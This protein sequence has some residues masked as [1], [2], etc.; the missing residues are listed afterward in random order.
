MSIENKLICLYLNSVWQSMGYKKV[1]DSICDLMNVDEKN[2]HTTLAVD[3]EY[4]NGEIKNPNPVIWEEWIN[5]PIRDSDF[6]IHSPKLT[7]RV[8]IILIEKNYAKLHKVEPR[9]S[10]EGIWRRDKGICQYSGEQLTKETGDIDHIIPKK[11]GGKETWE[12]L[13]LSS[14]RIN[15]DIKR[16]KFLHEIGLKLIKNPKAPQSIPISMILEPKLKEHEF[17]LSKNY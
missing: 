7:I 12:N 8:P 6:A 17:F 4:E 11:H 15:R 3:F 2:Q 10:R 16:D 1:A 9:L 13:C 14:K 5:L